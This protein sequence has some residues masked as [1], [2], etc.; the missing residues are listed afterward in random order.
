MILK[1]VELVWK[2]EVQDYC[3]L[4]YPNH[5]EGCP[6]YGTRNSC[7]PQA[8]LID[9]ILD[10]EQPVYA[11]I[12]EFDLKGHVEN[13][14]IYH[15]DWSETQL[16]NSRY[17]QNKARKNLREGIESAKINT[18]HLRNLLVLYRSEANGVHLVS[19]LR[20]VGVKINFP[21]KDIVHLVAIMGNRKAGKL[22]SVFE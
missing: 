3:K 10:L 21:P 15:P 8:P 13:L 5:P 11:A 4:P 20:K 17:W 14:R 2:P 22:R 7:P 12:L 9:E 6:M 19:T 1:Q 16:R 18:S